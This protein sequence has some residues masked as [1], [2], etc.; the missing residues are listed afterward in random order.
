MQIY[1]LN[2]KKLA[3]LLLPTFLRR[4]R[5]QAFVRVLVAPVQSLHN[6]LMQFR[7]RSLYQVQHNCQIIYLEAVLNDAFDPT[8]RRIRIL[9]SVFREPLYFYEPEQNLEVYFYE[10]DNQMPTYF[11]D[12]G[13][14][15][16]DGFDFVVFVPPDLQP[17]TQQEEQAML[18]KMRGLVDY[19]KL[20]SKN[21]TIKWEQ[22]ND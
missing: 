5:L 16:G 11:Y 13:D 2:F 15:A 10:P 3:V 22:V 14:F 6:K 4:E 1:N 9:N 20:Y 18:T 19:Y 8:F 7:E 17:Q 12:V 21:Y